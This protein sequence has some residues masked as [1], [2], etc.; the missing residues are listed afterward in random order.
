MRP[1][2][3]MDAAAP[4]SAMHPPFAAEI[5]AFSAMMRPIAEAVNI[6]LRSL[7]FPALKCSLQLKRTP[8][9]IPAPP[10]VGKA[11][12]LPMRAFCSPTASA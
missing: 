5:V 9:T 7:L 12:I 8:G 1:A 11:A 6:P 4:T 3:A 10:A 2:A